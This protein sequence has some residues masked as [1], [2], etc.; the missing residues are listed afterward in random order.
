LK[1]QKNSLLFDSHTS[2]WSQKSSSAALAL[3]ASCQSNIQEK[4]I[5]VYERGEGERDGREEKKK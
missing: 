4:W 5:S 1:D 2:G 3:F